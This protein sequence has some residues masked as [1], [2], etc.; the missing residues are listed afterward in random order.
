MGL[1]LRA[2]RERRKLSLHSLADRAGVSYVS[3]ARIESGRMSPTVATLEKLARA[4]GV[5]VRDLFPSK[6][7][8]RKR[9][10]KR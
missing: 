3:I 1:L 5:T 4:L 6:E 2:W 10:G 9:R 8:S 7:R